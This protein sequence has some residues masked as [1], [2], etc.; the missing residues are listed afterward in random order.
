VFDLP[1]L[2]KKAKSGFEA[3]GINAI[4]EIPPDFPLTENQ[5]RQRMAV[6]RGEAQVDRAALRDFLEGLCYPLYFLDFETCNPG[7]P[8]F[9]GFRPYQHVTYQYSLHKVDGPDSELQ[10]FHYLS[11]EEQD[12]HP[13]LVTR[14]VADLGTEGSVLV[15]NQSFE[16]GRLRELAARFSAQANRLAG[17]LDRMMDLMLVFR[18][19]A[20]VHPDFHGSY[21][22]KVVLP[23]VAPD[24]EGRYQDLG[25]S[26]G[27]E[28]MLAWLKL[29]G[30]EI[31]GEDAAS[32]TADLLAYNAL[33]TLALVEIWRRLGEL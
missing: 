20:Y 8:M 27:E 16:A 17:A 22:L 14:L 3:L 25:I 26:N 18:Q 12:P 29:V 33:D 10:H 6:V 2:S 7:I 32:M 23:V 19:G 15:W 21:S 28:A 13:N 9:P 24:F 30:A 5:Q 31:S 4:A 1:R 11:V